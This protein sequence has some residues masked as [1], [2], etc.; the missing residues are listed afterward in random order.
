MATRTRTEAAEHV[1]PTVDPLTRGDV[2]VSLRQ[3]GKLALGDVGIVERVLRAGDR[4]SQGVQMLG[5]DE[6]LYPLDGLR[7]LFRPMGVNEWHLFP[8][9]DGSLHKVLLDRHGGITPKMV[10]V[11]NQAL[12]RSLRLMF[13]PPPEQ[14]SNGK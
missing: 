11:L 6:M 3:Y 5:D 13:P 12:L 10:T 1:L 7:G 2:V 14:Q 9:S 8:D 4:K